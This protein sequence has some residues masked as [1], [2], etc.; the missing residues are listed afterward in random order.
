MPFARILNVD[1]N[2]LD[3]AIHRR[4]I[5]AHDSA[6]EVVDACHGGAALEV[7]EQGAFWPDLILLDVNMPVLDGF[8][9]LDR[10]AQTYGA[11]VPRTIL[12]LTSLFQDRDTDRIADYPAVAGYFLKP[13]TKHWFEKVEPLLAEADAQG[14]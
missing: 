8:E 12:T 9:F 10:A 1:D 4:R 2:A 3:L 5:L 7:L 6:I 13:L 11:R 14:T